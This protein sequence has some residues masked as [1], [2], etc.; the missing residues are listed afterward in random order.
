M[1]QMRIYAIFG[2]HGDDMAPELLDAIDEWS[3]EGNPKWI[4]ERLAHHKGANIYANVQ[5]VCFSVDQDKIESI[6]R[7]DQA[8]IETTDVHQFKQE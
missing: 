1:S 4:E 7:P 6:L 5:V 2:D 3:A 8:A